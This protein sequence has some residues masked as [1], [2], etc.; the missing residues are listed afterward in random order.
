MVCFLVINC[1]RISHPILDLPRIEPCSGFQEGLAVWNIAVRLAPVVAA[2]LVSQQEKPKP[3]L[4]SKAGKAQAKL[5]PKQ[6]RPKPK[7]K[8]EYTLASRIE[9]Q[10]QA[11]NTVVK[12]VLV[13]KHRV[14]CFQ[15]QVK[16]K[17][18]R[19]TD[20]YDLEVP[21]ELHPSYRALLLPIAIKTARVVEG[22]VYGGCSVVGWIRLEKS[23]LEDGW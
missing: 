6:G 11:K 13:F 15:A 12:C 22:L 3:K 16:L 23:C 21:S 1:H 7:I 9:A 20:R 19:H 5:K 4:K 10:A 17:T 14:S 2:R 18:P 8:P